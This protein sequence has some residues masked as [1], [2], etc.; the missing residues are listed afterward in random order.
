MVVDEDPGVKEVARDIMEACGHKVMTAATRG[1]ALFL[2]N[3]WGKEISIVLLDASH[4]EPKE[5]ENLF[6]KILEVNPAAKV[7]VTSIYSHDWS[8]GDIFGRGA[9]GFLKKPFRMTELLAM[10]QKVQ[11]LQ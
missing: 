9:A 4:A 11:G 6:Q 2:F 7:I 1:D 5:T 10:V 3:Q 8:S